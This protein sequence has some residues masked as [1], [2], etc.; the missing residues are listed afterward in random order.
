MIEQYLL[1]TD[2]D[3][4][5]IPNGPQPES[6]DAR[7]YFANLVS[8]PSVKLAYVSGRDLKLVEDAIIEFSLPIPDFIIGDVGSTIY[9]QHSGAKWHKLEQWDNKIAQ[10]WGQYTNEELQSILKDISA[11]RPQESDKQNTYK[12]SYY[13]PLEINKEKIL[14]EVR[15]ILDGIGVK[16]SLI[17][18]IDELAETGLLDILPARAS[19]LHAIEALIEIEGFDTANTVFSGDSGNDIEVL[20]SQI[21]ST[22][23]ANSQ[24][25]VREL[26]IQLSKKNGYQAELYLA[27]GK[28]EGLN[29]NYS[30]GIL[31][32]VLHYFPQLN[33][34]LS[35]PS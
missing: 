14:A 16:A 17:W 33:K 6:K 20:S 21:K 9:K 8:Q 3:R 31:E 27:K 25:E 29:G 5:L 12:L 19:K 32:G 13:L 34:I 23:V 11:L 4:T 2:L 18:S 15:Q 28:L 1:C 24:A 22:L 35:K 26:A 7:L 30:A 10:D